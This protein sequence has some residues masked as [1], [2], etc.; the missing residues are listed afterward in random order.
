M[1]SIVSSDQVLFVWDSAAGDSVEQTVA[2]IKKHSQNIKIENWD[3]LSLST[4][5]RTI[6]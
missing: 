2:D 1:E 5:S 6:S 4:Y 3:R